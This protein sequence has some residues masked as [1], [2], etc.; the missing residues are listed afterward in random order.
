MDSEKRIEELEKEV[1]ELK[2]LVRHLAHAPAAPAHAADAPAAPHRWLPDPAIMKDM[3]VRVDRALGGLD[4][5]SI[6]TKIGAVWLSRLAIVVVMTSIALAANATYLTDAIAPWQKIAMGYAVA[7]AFITYGVLFRKSHD[8]FSQ[9]ILGG[10]LATGYFAT[11]AAFFVDRIRIVDAPWL[12]VPV[13]LVCL[14]AIAGTA[15]WRQSQT[16]AGV[17]LFLTYYTIVVSSTGALQQDE[18]IYALATSSFLAAVVLVFHALHRWVLLSWVV[19][20]ATYLTFLL[21]FLE[22]PAGLEMADRS[23][24]WLSSSYLTVCYLLFSLICLIDARKTGDYRHGVAPMAGFN[25]FIFVALMWIAVRQHYPAE[26]WMFRAAYTGLLLGL[27]LLA[28]WTGPRRNYLFQVFIAKTIIMAT[29]TLEAYFSGEKLLIAMAIECFALSIGYR[30]S[31]L[32]IFKVMGLGLF[33][34][35]FIAMLAS[36]KM[37]GQVQIGPVA[38]PANWF[39][40]AGIAGAFAIVAWFYE[41]F[42]RPVRPETRAPRGPGMFSTSPLN[43]GDGAMAM[44]HA[45]G[46]ALLLLVITTIERSE[47][48][49]LPFLLTGEGA[50]LVLV[51]LLLRTQQVQTA[52]VLLF[53]AA[54]V[55]WYVFLWLP[56]PGFEMQQYYALYT[57]LLAILTYVG[58]YFWERYLNRYRDMNDFEHDATAAVPYLAA[59]FLLLALSSRLYPP[60]HTPVV[61]A[62]LGLLLLL[63]ALAT[64]QVGLKASAVLALTA[65]AVKFAWAISHPTTPVTAQPDFLLFFALFL[66]LFVLAERITVF[67][68]RM[69]AQPAQ[70]S[71]HLRTAIVAIAGALGAFGL[72]RWSDDSHFIFYLLTLAVIAIS[73][74]AVFREGR[75]RWGALLLFA[76]IVVYSF[77][78]LDRFSPVYQ[79]L[80][81]GASGSVLLVVSWGYSHFRQ[82]NLLRRP[83]QDHHRADSDEPA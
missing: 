6:E 41:I 80:I 43:I 29:L 51:G 37:P 71:N 16:V 58:A 30:R 36:M 23:Y 10:G 20:V 72:Y 17:S 32:T 38:F 7:A 82:R 83:A 13:L 75:Y 45:A 26:E 49:A 18:L 79:V 5:E 3:R 76:V 35:T 78:Y 50:L 60:L 74:G 21:F 59:T 70:V 24:F 22:K 54:H 1:N 55:T 66:L 69:E 25:S 57:V 12:A 63:G 39:S 15:H 2:E 68:A 53:A 31:G 8:M 67:L 27:A 44:L 64:G 19:L 62:A 47:D 61:Y 9:V 11:Y 73:L 46:A 81:F 48:V 52:S 56:R 14:L 28:A 34:I 42:I 65:G 33:V 77:S 4:E 40:A